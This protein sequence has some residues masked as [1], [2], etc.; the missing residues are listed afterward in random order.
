[1]QFVA[2]KNQES[3]RMKTLIAIVAALAAMT[4]IASAQR[5]VCTPQC[6]DPTDDR[7]CTK[8]CSRS[9]EGIQIDQYN[10]RFGGHH[11]YPGGG[12]VDEQVEREQHRRQFGY[13]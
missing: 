6:A 12:S 4:S 9:T 2:T 1:M 10:P 13:Y 11:L 7:T 5:L 8:S 3:F